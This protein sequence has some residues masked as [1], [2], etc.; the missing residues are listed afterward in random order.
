MNELDRLLEMHRGN[1]WTKD[2]V[3]E[4]NSLKSIIEEKIKDYDWIISQAKEFEK[5]RNEY[6]D[7]NE[8][9]KKECDKIT[10]E[11]AKLYLDNQHLNNVVKRRKKRAKFLTVQ[12]EQLKKELEKI[13]EQAINENPELFDE[14]GKK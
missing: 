1:N 9:I 10:K 8:K 6:R 2:L 5:Q 7:K 13:T 11:H 4:H 14:L 12:N 3:N